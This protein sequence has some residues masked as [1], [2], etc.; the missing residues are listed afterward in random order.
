MIILG[1]R[2]HGDPSPSHHFLVA[3][4]ECVYLESVIQIIF[5]PSMDFPFFFV[6]NV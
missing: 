1:R 6:V 4:V 2:A 5:T 3:T